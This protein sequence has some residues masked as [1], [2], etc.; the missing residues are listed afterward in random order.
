M[1]AYFIDMRS[2]EIYDNLDYKN[3]EKLVLKLAEERHTYRD[4]YAMKLTLSKT[5]NSIHYDLSKCGIVGSG[6]ATGYIYI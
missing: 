6:Q 1:A 5:V 3:K 2:K 4:Y